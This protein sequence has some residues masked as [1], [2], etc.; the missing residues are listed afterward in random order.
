MRLPITSLVAACCALASCARATSPPPPH[1]FAE[2]ARASLSQI[3]GRLV[4]AGLEADVQVLRDEWGVPHIYAQDMDD[5]FFAQGFVVAQ[6]RL[7]QMEIWRRT[8]EGRVSELV[9]PAGLPHDR[10]VRLLMFR[11]PVDEAEWASYHP[12]GK[13][14]FTAYA[15][16]INAFIASAGD[17]LPV[18]FKLTGTRPE[19][20]TPEQLLLRARVNDSIADARAELTLAR[21]VATLGLAEANRR[22]P[23]DV[24]DTLAVPEGLDVSVVTDEAIKALDGDM[25]GELPRPEILPRYRDWPGAT[26]SVDRGVP[27][28][29][30][31]SNNWA[32][33]GRR[34]G[35]GV[36]IMVDD[37]HRQVTN[38]PH[39]YLLHLNAPGWTVAGATE[40][41]LPGVIRGHNGRVAWGRTFTETDLADVYIETVNPANPN[42]VMFNG[43]WEPLRVITEEIAV[44]GAPSQRVELKFSRH[45]PIFHEDRERRV[46]YALRSQLQERGTAEYL[47]G[48]RLDQATSAKDCLDAANYMPMP[49][50]NLVCA[51]ADGNIA[52]RIAVFAPTRKGWTGRLPVPGT[53]TYEWGPERR[54]DLPAE[55]NPERGYITT[56]NNNTHPRDFRP[57]YAYYPAGGRY[58]R[59]ER[60]VQM[61][62]AAKS[63]TTDDM[64]RMLRDSYNSE[65]AEDQ[66]LFRGWT[67][68]DAAVERARAMVAGWDAVMDRGSAAAALYMSWR[69]TA[70]LGAARKGSREAVADGLRRAIESLAASQGA[71]WAGWRW[72]RM[73]QSE[74]PHPLV[75]AYDLPPIE[76]QGGAG[77][78]NAIGSVYRLVTNFRD[79]DQSMVTIGPGNSG[80]PGSPFYDNLHE[81]WGRNEFF[82][83]LFTRAAVE[84]KA[85]HRLTLSPR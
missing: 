60:I 11:G 18:E 23:T 50:T 5:L 28:L 77:T 43:K 26:A 1:T 30:P 68:S 84:A 83:L 51:D 40:A 32:I 52:F 82:P 78:V 24:G 42:E 80:Q 47:G 81:L 85:Q 20:W 9:G 48:L 2:L 33:S 79:P 69:R 3:D 17:N 14:I 22:A 34:T 61:I 76:R 4:V 74:F 10:L 27:E 49:P 63:F 37:P 12:E 8:G 16:G 36:A 71:D 72:G 56:A 64:M 58:R 19:P 46:A 38:P 6:D 65:A 44:R 70:D 41:G 13:R 53:G 7:W 59:H 29:S 54:T 75:G 31:G 55:Y 57:P 21:S 15:A 35:T 25:Y 62:E 45:G 67:S 39:R 66:P 73:N